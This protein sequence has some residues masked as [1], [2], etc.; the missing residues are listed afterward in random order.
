MIYDNLIADLNQYID[1]LYTPP[2]FTSR[3]RLTRRHARQITE[4]EIG[5]KLTNNELI[6]H[7]DGDPFNNAPVNRDIVSYAEHRVLHA[8]KKLTWIETGGKNELNNYKGRKL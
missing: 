4:E 3:L 8:K 6:H 5:R 1:L 2:L 7:A